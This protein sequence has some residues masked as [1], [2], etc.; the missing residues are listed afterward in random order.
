MQGQLLISMRDV[1]LTQ[2]ITNILPEA[3]FEMNSLKLTSLCVYI[4]I[5][6]KQKTGSQVTNSW[7][8]TVTYSKK[9]TFDLS[10]FLAQSS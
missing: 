10:L 7:Y 9:Y 6:T 3:H 2:P 1:E 8:E 5:H 4:I